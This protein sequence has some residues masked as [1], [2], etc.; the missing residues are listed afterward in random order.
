MECDAPGHREEIGD[1]LARTCVNTGLTLDQAMSESP[2]W[3]KMLNEASEKVEAMR[4]IRM[5]DAFLASG[6]AAFGGKGAD[7][8]YKSLRKDLVRSAFR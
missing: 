5:M 1:F 6:A 8:T 3:L 2:A 7:A 4:Q